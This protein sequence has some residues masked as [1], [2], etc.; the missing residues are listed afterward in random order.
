MRSLRETVQFMFFR[1]EG[2]NIQTSN[3]FTIIT[4]LHQTSAHINLTHKSNNEKNNEEKNICAPPPKKKN[5]Q[6]S[7]H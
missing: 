6:Y 4:P 2:G 3:L 5:Q 1:W 7:K